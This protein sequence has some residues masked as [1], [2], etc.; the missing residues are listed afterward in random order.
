MRGENFS[1]TAGQDAACWPAALEVLLHISSDPVVVAFPHK[2]RPWG[3]PVP[4]ASQEIL[5]SGFVKRTP[6][7]IFSIWG[8]CL[9]IPFCP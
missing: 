5:H 3:P 8:N 9:Y 4:L 6:G 1:L 2:K 7:T